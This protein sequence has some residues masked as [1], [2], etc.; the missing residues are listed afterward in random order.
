MGLGSALAIAGGSIAGSV[1]SGL[2]NARQASKNRDFQERMSNTSYQRAVN[3][4]RRAGLN[5]ILAA[6]Q[7]GA[8]TP[9]GAM[10]NMP[11]LGSS[12]ASGMQA[13][14]ASEKLPFEVQKLDAEV[15]KLVADTDVS[16]E[17]KDN[18]KQLT[19]KAWEDTNNAMKQGVSM[20][21]K[22]IVSGIL[23]DF[24]QDNPNLTILQEFGMDAGT[25]ADLIGSILKIGLG[26]IKIGKG[27]GN[28]KIGK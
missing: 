25:L 9:A 23:T 7:G 3:D 19:R 18:I 4:M 1:V 14:I 6:K 10:A 28:I 21:Y 20:D 5:P 22:N 15:D 24:K 17:Q 2:F 11:D 26:N 13:A 16:V 27:L 8:S 12:A